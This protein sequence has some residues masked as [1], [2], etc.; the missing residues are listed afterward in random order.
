MQEKSLSSSQVNK[1]GFYLL[2]SSLAAMVQMTYLT[3]FMT[4]CIKIPAGIV[5]TTLLVA[6]VIDFFIGVICGGIIEKVRMPWGKYRSW[7]LVL[8]W[9][10]VFSIVCS[11]FDT[12]AWP[13]GFRV[14][15]SFIGYMQV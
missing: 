3:I 12:S 5:A 14:G 8:R 2:T 11:F 6:R 13:L 9:V 15:V 4:D 7:L 1:Y 10:I